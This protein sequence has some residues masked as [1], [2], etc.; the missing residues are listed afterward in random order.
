MKKTAIVPLEL[1]LKVL[2]RVSDL[3]KLCDL[4]LVLVKIW[5][6]AKKLGSK[7]DNSIGFL[8]PVET[9]RQS[10][11][12]ST[13]TIPLSLPHEAKFALSQMIILDMSLYHTFM[14]L[15]SL[16]IA[17]SHANLLDIDQ[18]FLTFLKPSNVFES[19]KMMSERKHQATLGEEKS[20]GV[21]FAMFKMDCLSLFGRNI[22]TIE[23]SAL[24]DI[25]RVA[26]T[27]FLT[28]I[29]EAYKSEQIR[30]ATSDGEPVAE[31]LLN[32]II[33]ELPPGSTSSRV[34]NE[35]RKTFIMVSKTVS[36]SSELK[37]GNV[38]KQESI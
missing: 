29:N 34:I 4:E 11:I 27:N 32:R 10:P 24:D 5:K 33:S 20:T 16:C 38:F 12:Q 17:R 25:L 23:V 9:E 2:R 14:A 13:E 1:R 18:A 22:F 26:Y 21:V 35:A 8:D 31:L 19:N 37:L 28:L 3:C 30:F 6:I 7:L 15:V 36:W